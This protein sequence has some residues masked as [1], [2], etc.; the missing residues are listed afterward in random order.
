[1][2]KVLLIDYGDV[3]WDK[4]RARRDAMDD[5]HAHV[6]LIRAQ[7]SLVSPMANEAQCRQD[8]DDG[9]ESAYVT[10]DAKERLAAIARKL[11]IDPRELVMLNEARYPGLR[12]SSILF[13]G[14]RLLLPKTPGL[15]LYDS[16]RVCS[17]LKG[18]NRSLVVETEAEKRPHLASH[19][20]WRAVLGTRVRFPA[21][22]KFGASFASV[23]SF[24]VSPSVC[25]SRTYRPP[26]SVGERVE[27]YFEDQ[28]PMYL[29]R[30]V[31]VNASKRGPPT[32]D[33]EF[34]DGET[35][36]G[37]KAP[38]VRAVQP[39]KA[40]STIVELP[41][42]TWI[43]LND[44]DIGAA[45]ASDKL[46]DDK[47]LD[48][49]TR[50]W[51]PQ[52]VIVAVHEQGA[53]G[54]ARSY[55]VQMDGGDFRSAVDS[56]RIEP[57]L[58]LRYEAGDQDVWSVRSILAQVDKNENHWSILSSCPDPCSRYGVCEGVSRQRNFGP[59]SSRSRLLS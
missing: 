7:L 28:A 46:R 17:S 12:L 15:V 3:Y 47:T 9:D 41:E 58:L 18:N 54:M 31:S 33:V 14:T 26:L 21:K 8:N 45:Q 56:W 44:E 19:E 24:V 6:A 20:R 27:A 48:V 38:F 29:A 16:I 11:G 36:R 43:E 42:G 22:G 37:I 51:L 59:T 30:V 49:K 32:Y 55:D 2:V 52:G 34:D 1:V 5:V 25:D 53:S 23:A 13:K 4:W 40:S 10:Q 50:G 39:P 35:E 57:L